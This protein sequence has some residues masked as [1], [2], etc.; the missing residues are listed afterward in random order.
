MSCGTTYCLT[1]GEKNSILLLPSVYSN[2]I[3]LEYMFIYML[4]VF[5]Y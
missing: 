1:R 2:L 3:K 4:L 5:L